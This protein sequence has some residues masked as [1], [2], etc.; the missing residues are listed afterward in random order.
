MLGGMRVRCGRFEERRGE[1][2]ESKEK[3]MSSKS[4][5]KSAG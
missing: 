2:S 3:E 1:Q 4:L 5:M